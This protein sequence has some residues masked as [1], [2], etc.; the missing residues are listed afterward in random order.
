MVVDIS[1]ME[2]YSSPVNSAL[3]GNLAI[4]LTAVGLLLAVWFFIFEVRNL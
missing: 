4:S 3:Y 1:K 2:S